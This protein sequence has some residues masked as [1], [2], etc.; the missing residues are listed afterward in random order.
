MYRF[1]YVLF[2]YDFIRMYVSDSN[3]LIE[4]YAY[5]SIMYLM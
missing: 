3:I 2:E 5:N 1:F 4:T